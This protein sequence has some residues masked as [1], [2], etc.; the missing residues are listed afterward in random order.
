M[1][2]FLQVDERWSNVTASKGSCAPEPVTTSHAP[3]LPQTRYLGFKTYIV[4]KTE[5]EQ[6][7]LPSLISGVDLSFDLPDATLPSFSGLAG[8][9]LYVLGLS[10]YKDHN[11][12]YAKF[13]FHVHGIGSL[14]FPIQRSRNAVLLLCDLLLI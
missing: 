8:N 3:F 5:R 1:F 11:Y 7:T 12:Y 10:L 14:T 13:P 2:G 4:F 6:L 9:I